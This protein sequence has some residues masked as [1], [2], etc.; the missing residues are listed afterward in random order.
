MSPISLVVLAMAAS[1]A[2]PIPPDWTARRSQGNLVYSP[3]PVQRPLPNF[4]NGYAAT[5]HGQPTFYVA[6]VFSGPLPPP[7][8]TATGAVSQRAGLPMV[9]LGASGENASAL[10]LDFGH[11]TVEELLPLPNG[12]LARQTRY[13]H[14]GLKHL[15]VAQVELRAGAAAAAELQLSSTLSPCS[16]SSIA[17][18]GFPAVPCV[19]W[20][21]ASGP[22]G[23]ACY[24]ATSTGETCDGDVMCVRL[25]P[26]QRAGYNVTIAMCTD[27]DNSTLRAAAGSTRRASR[28]ASVWTSLES[29]APLAQ[30]AKE[31]SAQSQAVAAA[32]EALW[33]GH[34]QAMAA[35]TSVGIE[36]EE[37]AGSRAFA[38]NVNASLYGILI[39]LRDE[40]NYSTSP[41]GLPNGCYNGHAFWDVEQ[42]I[43][44][45]LLLLHPTMA[46]AAMQYRAD[47]IPQ[48]RLNALVMRNDSKVLGRQIQGLK[49]PWESA[50][51]GLANTP[52]CCNQNEYHEIHID[53]DVSLAMWQ[54]YIA[55]RDKAWLA[56]VGWP[57][58]QGIAQF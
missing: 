21:R 58:L 45:N 44:P 43:W 10:A 42:F 4:G 27:A 16:G 57:V 8:G 38:A 34:L 24:V 9:A 18:G 50:F 22:A 3:L 29:A 46:K 37:T 47:R 20:E 39:S 32:P 5:Q 36:V 48:A 14:R 26:A 33:P 17:T 19:P 7:F 51:S 11:A 53:G 13:F 12:A 15:L 41:G 54:V 2:L 1:A 23:A 31:W 6:G 28:L 40:L 56:R 49:F 25:L 35:L 52:A 30:A 55:S